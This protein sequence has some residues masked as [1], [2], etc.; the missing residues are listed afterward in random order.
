MRLPWPLLAGL[1]IAVIGVVQW[2]LEEWD[3]TW[4]MRLGTVV[5]VAAIGAAVAI[6]GHVAGERAKRSA[7]RAQAEE[8][9]RRIRATLLEWP[10]GKV[11]EVD[12]VDLGVGGPV[13]GAGLGPYVERDADRSAHE[14]LRRDGRLLFL[15]EAASGVT[16]TAF[17]SARQESV[18]RVVLAPRT[19]QSLREAF[20]ELDLLGELD[21]DRPVLFWLD[22][23]DRFEDAVSESV[24]AE[25][26]VRVRGS[27]VIATI[28]TRDY[29][30]WCDAQ[31]GLARSFGD[32]VRLKRL[33]SPEEVARAEAV[34]P[35]VDFNEGIAPAF[36]AVGALLRRWQGGLVQCVF[37]P[38]E[39]DCRLAE[40]VVQAVFDWQMTG[41]P[42]PL[43]LATLG[44]LLVVRTHIDGP[45]TLDHLDH[46]VAWAVAPMVQG[47]ALLTGSDQ[48]GLKVSNGFA[49]LSQL[50]DAPPTDARLLALKDA[51]AASDF[52]A[53]GQIGYAAQAAGEYDVAN[54][55]WAKLRDPDQPAAAWLLR[56]AQHSWD[57]GQPRHSIGPLERYLRL[58]EGG[59]D[60]HRIALARWQ[61]GQAT[62]SAG[63]PEAALEHLESAQEEFEHDDLANL[64][65]RVQ[66]VLDIAA[67]EAVIGNYEA[68][69]SRL[70]NLLGHLPADSTAA[71]M[72]QIE[73]G[74]IHRL[75]GRPK[76]AFAN[77]QRAVAILEPEPDQKLA[78]AL[79]RLGTALAEA[80]RF[81]DALTHYARARDIFEGARD[82]ANPDLA[83]ALAGIGRS[84]LALGRPN[85]AEK[86]FERALAIHLRALGSNHAQV[87]GI[88]QWLGQTRCEL[89]QVSQGIALLEDAVETFRRVLGSQHP[90]SAEA[91]RTL[92]AARLQRGE[93]GNSLDLLAEVLDVFEASDP[94]S[95]E[96][97]RTL[98]VRARVCEALHET[99]AAE[100]DLRRALNIELNRQPEDRN[101]REL[102]VGDLRRVA[103]D[104]VV[105][106]D[107]MVVRR[108]T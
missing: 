27:R 72:V 71:A 42:R 96:V 101:L 31:P 91:L 2:A 98:I 95:K 63:D 44:E 77:L 67:A 45:P 50:A 16:R 17:E 40:P 107:G 8:R 4:Q 66:C 52:D 24:I 10:L 41:T 104:L 49:R 26:L 78:T 88:K 12:P 79:D 76:K 38:G 54:E 43:S 87:A 105:F 60:K 13:D 37:E 85:D 90:A 93:T 57:Q 108:E 30:A 65:L 22:D 9:A 103:P 73:L 1:C 3:A 18:S 62:L 58:T 53:I 35:G 34:Y 20:D 39:G 29:A 51:I 11:T 89:R 46:V 32:P 81:E 5:G 83:N 80:G 64:D 102:L 61:L 86:P 68:A 74:E 23:V 59:E 21:T 14:K 33:A 69:R 99:A 48:D 97:V 70:A 94:M 25:L 19:A 6:E 55:A 7:S 82:F 15:G 84:Q 75:L 56:A 28:G 106:E 47:A 100:Q 36:S 92:V